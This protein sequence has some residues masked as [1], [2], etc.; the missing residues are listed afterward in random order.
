MTINLR[1]GVT[2]RNLEDTLD[3]YFLAIKTLKEEFK[4]Q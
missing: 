2:I 3:W 1:Y 4:L